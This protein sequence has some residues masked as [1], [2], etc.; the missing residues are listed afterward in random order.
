MIHVAFKQTTTLEILGQ[1]YKLKQITN[2]TQLKTLIFSAYELRPSSFE[3][4]LDAISWIAT[5]GIIIL[6]FWHIEKSTQ[7][8][9][10]S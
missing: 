4:N 9:R 2:K 7:P 5:T 3:H 10:T 1:T 8:E 6:A